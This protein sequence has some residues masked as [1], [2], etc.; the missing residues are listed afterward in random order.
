MSNYH[1]G[2]LDA[3]EYG[4]S[5]SGAEV[6][7]RFDGTNKIIVDGPADFK[8]GQHVSVV[9]ATTRYLP[10]DILYGPWLDPKVYVEFDGQYEF[11]GY[12]GLDDQ[13][14]TVYFIDVPAGRSD[15]FHWSDDMGRHWHRNVPRK[16]NE[17]YTLSGGQQIK[18]NPYSWEKGYTFGFSARTDLCTVIE[19][20]DGNVITL[21][22][23][24]TRTGEGKLL[25]DDT[26]ALNHAVKEA[27]KQGKNLF[28]PSGH[29]RISGSIH[30]DHTIGMTIAGSG[31]K[32][33]LL[34]L[35]QGVGKCFTVSYNDDLTIRNFTLEGGMGCDE[36]DRAGFIPAQGASEVWGFQYKWTSAMAFYYNQRVTIEKIHAK[37][38]SAECFCSSYDNSQNTR[39][40]PSDPTE[41]R[42]PI[43]IFRDCIVS[44]CARNAFNT[45]NTEIYNCHIYNVGGNTVEDASRYLKMIGC[46]VRNS[47]AVAVSNVRDR[48]EYHEHLTKG[49][50]VVE[51]NIFEGGEMNIGGGQINVSAG[52]SQV[53][54]RG[55]QFINYNFNA[56]WLNDGCAPC[57]LPSENTIITGN[58]I[59]M[60]AEEWPSVPRIAI[61]VGHDDVTVS[62]N[63]IFVRGCDE[64]VT[65]IVLCD[66]AMRVTVHDNIT[67]GIG[68]GLVTQYA[69]G[70]VGYAVG[71]DG[72]SF[73]RA[74][75]AYGGTPAVLRRR[76]HRYHGWGITWLDEK[77]GDNRFA[78]F[79]PDTLVFTLEEPDELYEGR[80]FRFYPLAGAR[81]SIHDN[82]LEAKTPLMLNSYSAE[83]AVVNGNIETVAK[84]LAAMPE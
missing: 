38:M 1:S 65:G 15:F 9:G 2:W 20:I 36:R 28:V 40:W 51:N 4:A 13:S 78:D 60:T 44:D 57:E 22:D 32:S 18:F 41:G 59:D 64:N 26:A 42:H 80:P 77:G 33:T 43:T 69:E 76:S 46:Y 10:P 35:S 21:R 37:R 27:K 14:W 54:I 74:D 34:D 71:E 6:A 55:N 61:F 63:Q 39:I 70:K 68:K 12:T 50:L 47:G 81:W 8:V 84:P 79:D 11:R 25:H 5:G 72:K 16:D 3:K 62:D 23:S 66:N 53:I 56:I 29:Y 19:A 49:H 30:V 24:A 17:W 73:L 48:N 7:C 75:H 45:E 52:S 67:R 58:S 31:M 82:I 83:T